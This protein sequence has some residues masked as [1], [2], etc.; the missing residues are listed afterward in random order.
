MIQLPQVIFRTR[1]QLR[2][3][4]FS[5]NDWLMP[6]DVSRAMSRGSPVT[7]PNSSGRSMPSKSEPNATRS[8]PKRARPP[9]CGLP[10]FCLPV[11]TDADYCFRFRS[12]R[13]LSPMEL[14]LP[15]LRGSA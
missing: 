11:Y 12:G 2:Q 13:R 6:D 10:L 1:S 14:Q 8:S 9:C 5:A 15:E 7:S 4:S 3:A